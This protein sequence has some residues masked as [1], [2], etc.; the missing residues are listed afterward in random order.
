MPLVQFDLTP[1]EAARFDTVAEI[2]K[3]ARKAQVH[4]SALRGLES[5]EAEHA[6]TIATLRASME[7]TTEVQA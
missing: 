2:E 5:A 3:R 6:E 4:I 1:E 7:V